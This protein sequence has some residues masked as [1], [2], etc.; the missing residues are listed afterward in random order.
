MVEKCSEFAIENYQAKKFENGKFSQ[1]DD[2]IIKESILAVFVNGNEIARLIYNP[3]Y[4]EQL[5][6][7]FLFSE[8]IIENLSDVNSV[9]Y[10][11]RTNSIEIILKEGLQ[12]N[13][14][15]SVRSVATGC[16][17]CLT[18][19]SPIYS[20]FFQKIESDVR[21]SSDVVLS[22]VKKL[23]NAS[24]TFRKTGGV[25]SAAIAENDNILFV[26]DDIG[27]HNAVDKVLGWQLQNRW[28]SDSKAIMLETGRISTEIVT[29]AVRGKFPILI[30]PSAPTSGALQLADSLN[31]TTIGFTRGERFN[32]Y[33]HSWRVS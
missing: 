30:S 26:C 21:I 28:P 19:V 12:G 11:E 9:N 29:K 10:S 31:L 5:A 18:T 23:Q 24:S 22:L 6:L 2:L 13:L 3:T 8:C 17:R 20:K 25:H 1:I 32:V 4:I 7:G 15:N 14:F 16:G 27:R 33:T